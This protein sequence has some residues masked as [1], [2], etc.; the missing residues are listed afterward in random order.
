[1]STGLGTGG[2]LCVQPGSDITSFANL[3]QVLSSV[4]PTEM[5]RGLITFN[6][7]FLDKIAHMCSVR[8]CSL[9]FINYK[10]GLQVSV[11]LIVSKI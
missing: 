8:M 10:I 1:M 5:G 6:L 9:D 11:Q 2:P 7:P 4:A 3:G